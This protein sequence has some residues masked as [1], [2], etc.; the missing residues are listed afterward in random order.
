[1]NFISLEI[2][3]NCEEKIHCKLVLCV[4]YFYSIFKLTIIKVEICYEA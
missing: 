3:V 2:K 4:K 1:M